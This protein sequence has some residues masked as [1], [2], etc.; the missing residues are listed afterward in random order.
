M[1]IKERRR[2]TSTCEKHFNL[3]VVVT[4]A[5]AAVVDPAIEAAYFHYCHCL[6]RLFSVFASFC[7]NMKPAAHLFENQFFSCDVYSTF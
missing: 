3:P 4:V 6:F 5:I 2:K 1:L 7:A